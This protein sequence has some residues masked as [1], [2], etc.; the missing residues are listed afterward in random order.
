[1]ESQRKLIKGVI[2]LVSK[3]SKNKESQ[4]KIAEKIFEKAK[5]E[6]KQESTL[7]GKKAA[8][9]MDEIMN[10]INEAHQDSN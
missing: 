8:S 6:D 4:L 2:I 10:L 5:K 9:D 7:L 3:D 1:M